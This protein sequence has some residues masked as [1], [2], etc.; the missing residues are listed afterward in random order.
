MAECH[1]VDGIVVVPFEHLDGQRRA[2]IPQ[3]QRLVGGSAEQ[4]MGKRLREIQGEVQTTP[5]T[6]PPP[7]KK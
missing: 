4:L 3:H 6:P 7:K 5:G 2:R 1:A